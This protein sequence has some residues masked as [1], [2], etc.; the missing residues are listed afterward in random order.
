MDA[1]KN[2]KRETMKPIV[3]MVVCANCKKTFYPYGRLPLTVTPPAD[4]TTCPCCGNKALTFFDKN[5]QE[6]YVRKN[7]L[8]LDKDVIQG[9]QLPQLI[10]ELEE[11][12]QTFKIEIELLKKEVEANRETINNLKSRIEFILSDKFRTQIADKIVEV[13]LQQKKEPSVKPV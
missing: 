5:L 8:N 12:N 2:R 10:T 3:H 1:G 6:E 13:L 7:V 11:R 4:F 9:I